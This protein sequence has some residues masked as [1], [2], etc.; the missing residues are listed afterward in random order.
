FGTHTAIWWIIRAGAS[1]ALFAP[2]L[3]IHGVLMALIV[4]V[5]FVR[6]HRPF[7]PGE[8]HILAFNGYIFSA[9]AVLAALAYPW[10]AEAVL[11]LYPVFALLSGLYHLIVARLYW[12]PMYLNG[13]AY[14]LLALVMKLKPEWA[15]LEYAA[16]V[17]A[18]SIANGLVLRR[19]ARNSH[20][21]P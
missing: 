15:P 5:C 3:V 7:T 6:R 18:H 20:R 10:E 9:A 1:G 8:R 13:L 2:C 19:Y 4:R 12:G 16:L 14:Y 21:E 17:T 11:A